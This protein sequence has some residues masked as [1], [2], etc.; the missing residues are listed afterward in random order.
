MADRLS[1]LLHAALLP[2]QSMRT[3][4]ERPERSQDAAFLTTDI[5]LMSHND[6]PFKIE[7]NCGL[8]F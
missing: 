4:I 6:P 8:P 2:I 1:P 5:I 3:R 7:L